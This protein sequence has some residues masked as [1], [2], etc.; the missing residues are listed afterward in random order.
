MSLANLNLLVLWLILVYL[1][2]PTTPHP[3]SLAQSIIFEFGIHPCLTGLLMFSQHSKAQG[4]TLFREC[5][6]PRVSF[7]L[8]VSGDVSLNPSLVVRNFKGCLLYI[9]SIKN[10][11]GAFVDFGST[12]KVGLTALTETCLSTDDT[13]NAIA[14]VT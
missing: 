6:S 4:L 10:K 5:G 14:S 2:L 1:Y 13:V 9:R 12:K 11:Y 7:L 3:F 8:V